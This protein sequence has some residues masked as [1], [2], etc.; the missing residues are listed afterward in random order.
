LV[1][2]GSATGAACGGGVAKT[3]YFSALG[4]NDGG[5]GNP[6][7]PGFTSTDTTDPLNVRFHCNVG[8]AGS[9]GSWSPTVTVNQ[10]PQ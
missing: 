8:E 10:T 7:G 6:G 2:Q 9:G 3:A 1:Y 5:A 4:E